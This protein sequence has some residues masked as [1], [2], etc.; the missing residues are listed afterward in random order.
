MTPG[1]HNGQVSETRSGYR[2]SI[3]GLV[4]AILVALALI[5]ALWGMTR[6]VNRDAHTQVETVDYSASLAT[7]RAR[8]PFDVLAPKPVQAGWRATSVQWSGSGPLVSWHLGFLTARGEYVGL[9]QGNENSAAFVTESTPADEP[10]PPV[11]IDGQ[12]WASLTTSDGVEHA[13]VLAQDKVTTVV[14]GTVT[15]SELVAYVK[16]LSPD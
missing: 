10:G 16:S 12:V 1:G 9:E 7:A 15:Q 6:L 4:G 14:T 11:E 2:Q 8:A 3:G 13:L 5:L